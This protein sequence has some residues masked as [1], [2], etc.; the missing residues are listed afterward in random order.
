[1]VFF[2]NV[3]WTRKYLCTASSNSFLIHVVLNWKLF[4]DKALMLDFGMIKHFIEGVNKMHKKAGV[5]F[6]FEGA[7]DGEKL[8]FNHSRHGRDIQNTLIHQ[9]KTSNTSEA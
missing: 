3:L 1:M 8:C 7:E 5:S 4:S 6:Y 9:T 2:H